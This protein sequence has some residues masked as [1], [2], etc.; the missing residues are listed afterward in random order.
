MSYADRHLAFVENGGHSVSNEKGDDMYEK[1][2]RRIRWQKRKR[3]QD[4]YV[5]T[6]APVKPRQKTIKYYDDEDYG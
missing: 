4:D 6:R 5:K 1:E 2:L 3:R